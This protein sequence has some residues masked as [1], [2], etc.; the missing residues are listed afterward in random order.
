M[1]QRLH[2]P[3]GLRSRS[4]PGQESPSDGRIYTAFG[5]RLHFMNGIS[6]SSTALQV[7]ALAQFLSDT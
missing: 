2:G 3:A 5:L 6:A 1:S 4:Q 7:D